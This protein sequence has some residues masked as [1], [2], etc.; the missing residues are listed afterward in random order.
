MRLIWLKLLSTTNGV[1][2]CL[3]CLYYNFLSLLS[4]PTSLY[5]LILKETMA[6]HIDKLKKVV[7]ESNYYGA[8]Q[9]YKSISARSLVRFHILLNSVKKDEDAPES[10]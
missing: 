3:S 7:D 4:P 2:L 1:F 10:E 9:M 6:T 8:L 5:I